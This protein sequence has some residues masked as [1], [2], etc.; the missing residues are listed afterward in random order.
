MSCLV[1][2]AMGVVFRAADDVAELLVPFVAEQG[3]SH[4]S[5]AIETA[6]IDAS[7]GAIGADEFWQRV[8]LDAA[9]EEDY[10]ARHQLV[11]G[12]SALMQ[13]AVDAGIALWC[14]S[15]DVGRWSRRLRQRLGLE[16][17]FSGATISGDV[18][19]RKPDP[20]IYQAV[21]EA[22]GHA[23][24][25]LLFVDDRTKNVDAARAAGI[26]T[27]LFDRARGFDD[28]HTWIAR[29]GAAAGA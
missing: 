13:S 27:I 28:I 22:S 12:V 29:H 17:Y 19:L 11:T 21:L 25:D 3:G 9:V 16:A 15:N 14:L 18:G 10:L 7:L 20:A 2:D 6:Y 8:G 24:A 1:L 26:E 5:A 23:A 4:D